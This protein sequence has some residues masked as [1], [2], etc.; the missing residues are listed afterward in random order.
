MA[1]HEQS[2]VILCGGAGSRLG[3][4]TQDTPKTLLPLAGKP[5]L[6]RIIE[7]HHGKGCRRF[8]LCIGYKGNEIRNYVTSYM[9]T[10]NFQ[11]EVF[12]SDVG[13]NASMLARLRGSLDFLLPD[14]DAFFI[15]YGDTLI[16][17]DHAAMLAKQR[18]TGARMILTTA[19]VR[20]PYGQI[21]TDASG[22][23]LSF[24]EKPLQTFYIGH[25]LALREVIENAPPSIVGAPDALGLIQTIQEL[26]DRKEVWIHP[27]EGPQITFNT[28][29]E[30]EK[31]RQDIIHFYSYQQKDST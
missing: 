3:H 23:A 7:L 1:V 8:V 30:L 19:C 12:F 14:E 21:T 31:A 25:M 10:T 27:Y 29:F 20:S 18:E 28:A 24:V 26:I 11:A 5:I 6:Q 16:N 2:L 13:E 22:R 4:F 15:T 17:V 9:R